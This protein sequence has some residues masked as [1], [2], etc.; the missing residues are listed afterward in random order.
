MRFFVLIDNQLRRVH[1]EVV[2]DGIDPKSSVV[3][4]L[5]SS[6]PLRA[7]RLLVTYAALGALL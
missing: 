3:K 4:Q 6:Q 2:A 7:L 5:Q 1:L